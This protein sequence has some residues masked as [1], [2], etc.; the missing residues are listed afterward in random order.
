MLLAADNDY[1]GEAIAWHCAEILKL[2]PSK[3][4]RATFTEITKK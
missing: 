3:R 2:P 4:Y 1:E